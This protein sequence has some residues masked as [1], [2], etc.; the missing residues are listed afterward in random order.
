MYHECVPI[1]QYPQ[2]RAEIVEV[3]LSQWSFFA[4]AYW[5]LIAIEITVKNSTWFVYNF[6]EGASEKE[7]V[8]NGFV[9]LRARACVCVC[10]CRKIKDC[11]KD[12]H[13]RNRKMVRQVKSVL[14]PNLRCH[15]LKHSSDSE[16]KFVRDYSQIIPHYAELR[17]SI[18]AI[19]HWNLNPDSVLSGILLYLVS[20]SG[21]V[22]A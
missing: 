2:S 14:D 19:P 8:R 5:K 17:D 16:V 7:Q 22:E 6:W 12:M 10:V 11:T 21:R 9:Q 1:A 20:S 4:L 15:V 13:H 18:P 3:C